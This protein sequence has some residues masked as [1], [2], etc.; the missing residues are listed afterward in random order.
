MPPQGQE[1]SVAYCRHSIR[2]SYTEKFD[3]MSLVNKRKHD[4]CENIQNMDIYGKQPLCSMKNC[5]QFTR[6]LFQLYPYPL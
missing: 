2:F 1:S 4:T 5:F 6:I 3:Q